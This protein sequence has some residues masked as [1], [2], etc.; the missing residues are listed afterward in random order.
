MDTTPRLNDP[1]NTLLK[2]IC[3]LLQGGVSSG[4]LSFNARSGAITLLSADVTGALGY[5]PVDKAGDTMSGTLTVPTLTSTTAI[6]GV[7]ETLSGT[8]N[9]VGSQTDHAIL[10]RNA[11]DTQGPTVRLRKRGTTGN[12]NAA[13][14]NNEGIFQLRGLAWDGTDYQAAGRFQ[15]NANGTQ[16]GSNHSS[17]VRWQ[18]CPP[19]TTTEEEL[20]RVTSLATAQSLVSFGGVA[21]TNPAIKRSGAGLMVRLGDDSNYAVVQTGFLQANIADASTNTSPVA[22]E[23]YHETVGGNGATND[24]VSMDFRADS[25]TT[26]RQLQARIAT[27]WTDATH[28]TR[29]SHMRFTPTTNGT[30]TEAMRVSNAQI[31]AQNGT[32][33]AVAGTKVVDARQTGWTAATGT[34]T[35][36]TFA[37]S[38]VTLEVL[39]QHV[40]ALIDDLITHGLIGT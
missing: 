16:S 21:A 27:L 32:V 29:T 10:T 31:S 40:K 22:F 3:L 33:F 37:T 1:D 23:V 12:A 38:T 36:T 39:A 30:S 35:R 28:A 26:D 15:I 8:L 24:G 11:A 34:A 17:Y 25:S 6:N 4:V 7:D 9:I 13:V 5:T 14:S 18:A 2:K 20:F 19:N